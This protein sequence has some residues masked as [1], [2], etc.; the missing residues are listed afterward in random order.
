MLPRVTK[1]QSAVGSNAMPNEIGDGSLVIASDGKD[2][3]AV[4][5]GGREFRIER[6]RRLE[7]R[8]G[9]IIVS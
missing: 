7:I 3:P 8:E 1:G 4:K 2:H 6:D 9:V 5:I